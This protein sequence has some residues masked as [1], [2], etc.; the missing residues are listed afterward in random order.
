[1]RGSDGIF[2]IF[3]IFRQAVT[4]ALPACTEAMVGKH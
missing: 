2:R 4:V 1:M 3:A